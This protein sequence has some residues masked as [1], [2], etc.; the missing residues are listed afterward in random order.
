MASIIEAGLTSLYKFKA[1]DKDNNYQDILRNKL[2]C[3]SPSKLN[4]PFDSQ[5]PIRYDLC[6]KHE[7]MEIG[8]KF[9]IL[10]KTTERKERRK[11]AREIAK[12][13]KK[14]LKFNPNLVNSRMQEYVEANIKLFSFTEKRE[15]LL[16]WSHYADSHKGF[17]IEFSAKLLSNFL[18]NSYLKL[19]KTFI[20]D[21]VSYQDIYPTI[22]PSKHSDYERMHL[23]FFT[24]SNFW[25]YEN[26]W[27]IILLEQKSNYI[28]ILPEIIKNIYFGLLA[29]EENIK[30]SIEILKLYN[31][32]IGIYKAVK[33][34]E[35]FGLEFE[36]INTN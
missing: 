16:L 26:E 3:P 15:N 9:Y 30:T 34:K 2:Y 10:Q 8:K 32:E 4:D 11:G 35:E 1:F 23:Q 29:S 33:K 21:K 17:C 7:L 36:I 28:P 25:S 13:W 19:K 14:D 5:I 6:T 18:V 12:K 24:K 31:P 22:H 20:I 27:R